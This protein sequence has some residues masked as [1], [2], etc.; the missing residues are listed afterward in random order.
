M[1]VDVDVIFRFSMRV[2]S[3]LFGG[4]IMW[5][6]RL[7]CISCKEAK[8]YADELNHLQTLRGSFSAVSTPIFANKY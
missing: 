1:N 8:D 5:I 6:E 2:F 3:I 4:G 7:Q